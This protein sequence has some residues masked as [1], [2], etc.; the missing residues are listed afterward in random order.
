MIAEWESWPSIGTVTRSDASSNPAALATAAMPL[1]DPAQKIGMMV[2]VFILAMW[3]VAT[4]W[5]L[6]NV[7]VF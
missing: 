6:V 1:A 3:L 2:L 5:W 7:G 4:G